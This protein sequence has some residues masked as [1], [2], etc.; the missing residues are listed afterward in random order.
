MAVDEACTNVI[1]HAHKFD[2]RRLIDISIQTDSQKMKITITD[3]GAGF[4]INEIK[5]TIQ[6]LNQIRIEFKNMEHRLKQLEH[7]NNN[8]NGQNNKQGGNGNN[9]P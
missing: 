3:K 5:D 6:E 9:K 8:G 2:S 7:Q 1:K 4:E